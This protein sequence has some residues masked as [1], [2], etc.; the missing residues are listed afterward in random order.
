[1]SVGGII[2]AGGR[3]SRAWGKS[4]RPKFILLED[5]E[6]TVIRAFKAERGVYTTLVRPDGT[7]EKAWAGYSQEML[8]D[9]GTRIARLA[10]VPFVEQEFPDA[11]TEL[12]SGCLFPEP[13]PA[14]TTDPEPE[15]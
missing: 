14:P 11:P 5:P 6:Q 1:L 13:E 2:N 15:S 3:V 10:G 7:I 8:A 9:L 12:T 4:T